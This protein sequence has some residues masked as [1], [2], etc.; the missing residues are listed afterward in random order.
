MSWACDSRS[1]S[2]KSKLVV[3]EVDLV[4]EDENANRIVIENQLETTDH[5]HLGKILTYLTNLDAK[6]A[7]YGS[8][9]RLD[10]NT[11]RQ[12]RG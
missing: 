12:L 8:R 5:D 6:T 11:S 1:P 2:A 7:R 10:Q 4:A 3:F 9:R